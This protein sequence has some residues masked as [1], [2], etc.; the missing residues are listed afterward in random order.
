[1]TEQTARSTVSPGV[2]V[3]S[4][5]MKAS[6]PSLMRAALMR[7][8]SSDTWTARTGVKPTDRDA[9]VNDSDVPT[10]TSIVTVLPDTRNRPRTQAHLTRFPASGQN[11]SV[12]CIFA[13]GLAALLWA[14][15]VRTAPVPVD[16][17]VTLAGAEACAVTGDSPDRDTDQQW[18]AARHAIAIVTESVWKSAPL[19]AGLS[20]TPAARIF[21]IARSV[22]SPAPPVSS[23]QF[24]LRH[25]PL[26][27]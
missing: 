16:G 9:S 22:S 21:D 7:S 6:S 13:I 10:V 14:T 25:T 5:H 4:V 15:S 8:R 26:L 20:A 3:A 27:I 18:R 12:R 11:A 2:S 23:A 19:H 17:I 1:M 24:Y